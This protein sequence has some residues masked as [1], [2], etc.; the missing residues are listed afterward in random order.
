MPIVFTHTGLFKGLYTTTAITGSAHITQSQP[1][2]IKPHVSPAVQADSHG[3]QDASV[4][5]PQFERPTP[6]E[7]VIFRQL[8]DRFKTRMRA[9][10]VHYKRHPKVSIQ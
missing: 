9:N 8:N 1:A 10:P 3:D 2:A 6:K 5:N 4:L 7:S